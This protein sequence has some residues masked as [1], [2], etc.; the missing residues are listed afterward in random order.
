MLHDIMRSSATEYDG[1]KRLVCYNLDHDEHDDY[2]ENIFCLRT[3]DTRPLS[4]SRT[5]KSDY[6]SSSSPQELHRSAGA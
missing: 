6:L 1:R 2:S 3:L 5:K 4:S